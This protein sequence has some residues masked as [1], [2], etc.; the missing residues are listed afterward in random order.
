MKIDSILFFISLFFSLVWLLLKDVT[1]SSLFWLAVLRYLPILVL[2]VKYFRK[3]LPAYV[4]IIFVLFLLVL[5]IV[6]DTKYSIQGLFVVAMVPITLFVFNNITLS[7]RQLSHAVL[8]LLFAYFGYIVV[9]V[10]NRAYINPNLIAFTYLILS[11]L[12]FY[13]VY[14]NQKTTN[15]VITLLIVALALIT[16]LLIIYTESRNSLLVFLMLPVAFAFRKGMNKYM[17]LLLW[18]VLILFIVYPWI[19]CQFSENYAFRSTQNTELLKQDFFSGR[20]IIWSYVINE[21]RNPSYFYFGG[22]DTEWWGKS[23]HNS[24]LD[25]VARYGVPSMIVLGLIIV[26]YF[27]HICSLIENKYKS[28]LVLVLVAMIWGIN[29]SGLFLGYSF[30]LFLPYC[31]IHSKNKKVD[32]CNEIVHYSRIKV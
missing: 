2:Y 22:I 20:E 28:L 10:I 19:Y 1:S 15:V 5:A 24:A 17:K 14:L 16:I 26:Y 3:S 13:C 25:I 6:G 8:M 30:F 11:L 4:P 27:N 7:S 29:E 31:I 18:I 9:S 21:L 23:L 32:S 12:L